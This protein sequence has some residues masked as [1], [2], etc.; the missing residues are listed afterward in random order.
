[1]I[2]SRYTYVVLLA[3]SKHVSVHSYLVRRSS[4]AVLSLAGLGGLRF[5]SEPPRGP[6]SRFFPCS[7]WT[8]VRLSLSVEENNSHHLCGR[9]LLQITIPPEGPS[10]ERNQRN[11][12]W[13]APNHHVRTLWAH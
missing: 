2:L 7:V 13:P 8:V 3:S 6:G 5:L 12:S 4:S 11:S 9:A 1:M 10:L